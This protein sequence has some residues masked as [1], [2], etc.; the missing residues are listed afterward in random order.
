M[1]PAVTLNL[2]RARDSPQK[3]S[4]C[5]TVLHGQDYIRKVRMIEKD[6]FSDRTENSFE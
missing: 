1:D 4:R 3:F 6:F 5:G 2:L